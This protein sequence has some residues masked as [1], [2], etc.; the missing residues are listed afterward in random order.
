MKISLAQR[1]IPWILVPATLVAAPLTA[2]AA[3]PGPPPA[4][5]DI[6]LPAGQACQGFAL[7]VEATGSKAHVINLKNASII[8][9]GKGY[10]L[11]F[12]NVD[13]GET[14]TIAASGSVEKVVPNPDGRT[15]T[16]QATGG[17]VII[18]FPTDIPAG[19]STILYQGRVLYT[20][21]ADF[22]FTLKT[23]SGTQRDICAE[24]AS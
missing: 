24:L 12:T 21:D 13:T 5:V 11:T 19:P 8:T 22:N 2:S 3:P 9:A 10:T 6:T 1:L 23:S 14:I 16:V 15:F 7:R 20:R 4:D 17:N 18:L